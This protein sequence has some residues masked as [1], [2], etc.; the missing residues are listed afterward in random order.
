MNTHELITAVTDHGYELTPAGDKIK[1]QGPGGIP[2]DLLAKLATHKQEVLSYLTAKEKLA[3]LA[4]EINWDL[5]DLLD[6]FKDDDDM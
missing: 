5:Y 3:Y 6:W 1:Y 4:E 2:D